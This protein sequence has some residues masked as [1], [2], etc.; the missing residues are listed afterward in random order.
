MYT[1]G[2]TPPQ[3]APQPPS[4][5]SGY[6]TPTQHA[7]T[8][9][10]AFGEVKQA[11]KVASKREPYALLAVVSLVCTFIWII[12]PEDGKVGAQ[13]LKLWTLFV[14]GSAAM[15]FAPMTRKVFRLADERAWQFA[16]GGA[17]GMGFAWVAFLLPS[18]NSNQAFFGT[19]ATAAAGLAAWTAPGRNLD[20]DA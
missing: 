16:V 15:I 8:A 3:G 5:P 13:N 18:I 4:A 17:A 12:W 9:Q 7:Q 14:L 10:A 6:F 19:I 1:A 2:P 20:S 11:V